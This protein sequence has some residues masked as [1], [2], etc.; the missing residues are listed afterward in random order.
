[1]SPFRC[2]GPDGGD[3]CRAV[4]VT[5]SACL[6]LGSLM[7]A[8]GVAAQEPE[9]EPEVVR[10]TAHVRDA[11]TDGVL[12]GALIELSG[13]SR[14]YVTGMQG[15]VSFEIP[16]GDYT[17]TV[18]KGGYATLQGDFRAVYDGDLTVTM[19]ELGDVDTNIPGRLLVRVAEFASGRLIEGAAVSLTGGQARMTDGQGWV[20]FTDLSGPVAEVTVRGFGYQARTAPVPLHEGRTTIVEVAM[21]IDAVV[22]APIEVTAESQF[23]EQQGVYWRIDRGWPRRLLTRKQLIEKAVPRLADAFRE[24]PGVRVDYWGPFAFLMTHTGCPIPVYLDGKPLG[25]NIAA[26]NFVV[27]LNIDDIEAEDVELAEFYEPGRVPGRFVL[28]SADNC[29]AVLLWSRERAGKGSGEG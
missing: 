16:V 19:H 9:Q 27:G 8:F 15:R 2:A 17:F 13:Q 18:H 20:E 29:G 28:P 23:L 14:R 10:I 7:A 22:L 3:G 25:S 26:L 24:M 5:F 6:S 21:A 11:A 1:M 12:R 4:A